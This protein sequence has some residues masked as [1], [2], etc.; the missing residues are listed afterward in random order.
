MELVQ[1]GAE[2]TID[3]LSL[4]MQHILEPKRIANQ[5]DTALQ[6]KETLVDV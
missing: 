1:A 2:E 3:V 4:N 5:M 6:K